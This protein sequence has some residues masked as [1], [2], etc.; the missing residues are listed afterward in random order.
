MKNLILAILLFMSSNII[1]GQC[2]LKITTNINPQITICKNGNYLIKPIVNI[3]ASLTLYKDNEFYANM[4]EG[5]YNITVIGKYK[6]LATSNDDQSCTVWSNEFTVSMMDYPVVQ[7]N[8]VKTSF[9]PSELLTITSNMNSQSEWNYQWYNADVPLQGE[10][11]NNLNVSKTGNYRLEVSKNE[12]SK[13]SDFIYVKKLNAP[14]ADFE[15]SLVGAKGVNLTN[16]TTGANSFSWEFGDGGSSKYTNPSHTYNSNGDYNITLIATSDNGCN[17]TIVKKLTIGTTATADLQDGSI[18]VYPNP[19]AD[20]IRFDSNFDISNSKIAVVDQ[21]GKV[22]ELYIDYAQ[23]KIDFSNV[24][25]GI[26]FVK[27]VVGEKQLVKKVIK[28]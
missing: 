18:E 21:T 19:T 27:V 1:S 4:D 8:A 28:I 13:Y 6:L 2:N 5:Y 10:I 20:I 7:I 23:N 11:S 22:V 14:I 3:P 15:L 24:T 9:C 26:Y 17:D 16:T 12:C 25:S